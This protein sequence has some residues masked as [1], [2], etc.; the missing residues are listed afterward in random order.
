[1]KPHAPQLGS[2]VKVER[3]DGGVLLTCL[4]SPGSSPITLTLAEPDAM[5]LVAHVL[6]A[7]AD[8]RPGSEHD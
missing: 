2:W 1:V 5:K 6:H 3:D 8:Q 7:L 4:A